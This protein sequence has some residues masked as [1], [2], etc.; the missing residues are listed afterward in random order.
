MYEERALIFKKLGRHEAVLSIYIGALRDVEKAI[1]Y[2]KTV[3]D[4]NDSSNKEVFTI[5][6]KMLLNP[7]SAVLPGYSKESEEP[8]APDSKAVLRLLKEYAP[9]LDPIQAS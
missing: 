5:L 8:I 3:Y 6:L 4:K 2:C 1:D 9:Y 7:S